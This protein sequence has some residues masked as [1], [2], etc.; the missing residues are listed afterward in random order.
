MQGRYKYNFHRALLLQQGHIGRWRKNPSMTE[1][2]NPTQ[3]VGIKGE[4][5]GSG[6][7]KNWDSFTE[8]RLS[9]TWF[10]FTVFKNEEGQR[11]ERHFFLQNKRYVEAGWEGGDPFPPEVRRDTLAQ[12]RGTRASSLIFFFQSPLSVWSLVRRLAED[13]DRVLFFEEL[14]L[15]LL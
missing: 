5:K 3:E 15:L 11:R 13:D 6:R 12:P 10:G 8:V 9:Q 2:K 14:W 7:K 4:K 1:Y